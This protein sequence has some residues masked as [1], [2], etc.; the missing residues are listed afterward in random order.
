MVGVAMNGWQSLEQDSRRLWRWLLVAILVHLPLTP[1]GPLFGLLAL[2]SRPQSEPLPVE[3][4]RGIPVELLEQHEKPPQTAALEPPPAEPLPERPA[5]IVTPSVK[6]KHQPL[7]Q[8]AGE[9]PDAALPDD[10][11]RP[12]PLL[13][14]RDTLA[15]AGALL[16]SADAGSQP[17]AAVAEQ[18]NRANPEEALA[19]S[20]HG[21]ADSNANVR[22]SLFMDRVRQHPL[23]N[24]F[25]QLLKSVYQWRDF[26]TPASLDPVK[27]FDRIF[28]FGPQLRDSSQVAAFLQHNMRPTRIRKAIDGLVKRSGTGSAW[29]KGSKIP[30]ARAVA[31]R[32]QRLFV[33]YPNHVVAVVPPGAEKDALSLT[34]LKLPAAKGEELARAFVKTPSRAL[35]GTRYQLA[36][37]IRTAE[38]RVYADDE[39]GARIEADLEDESS[40]SAAHNS[41]Q[42]KREVDTMTLANSWLLSGSRVAEPLQIRTEENHI[43]ATL[44]VTR[45]QAERILRIAEAY[46]TPEGREPVHRAVNVVQLDGGRPSPTPSSP[47]PG[48]SESAP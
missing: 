46:L 10:A 39:G 47:R 28:L 18:G 1:L 30:A 12:E 8:D 36:P 35:L 34:E 40:E 14:T 6:P 13:V 37:S 21:I 3:E 27:D 33:L 17:G 29:L 43:H 42:I 26:F 44:R 15:D 20:T 7:E 5:A 45:L 16:A 24:Q 2:I 48:A 38:V 31:D 25:G 41:K 19:A 32:S 22:L 9:V 11:G 4:L 23:G